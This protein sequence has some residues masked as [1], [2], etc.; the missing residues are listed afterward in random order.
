MA[1]QAFDVRLN[2][3]FTKKVISVRNQTLEELTGG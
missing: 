1:R 2:G 3:M